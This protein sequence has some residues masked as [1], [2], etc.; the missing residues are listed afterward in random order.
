M[1]KLSIKKGNT[2]VYKRKL[3]FLNVSP[4]CH[5]TRVEQGFISIMPI[6]AI[7]V[8]TPANFDNFD[9]AGGSGGHK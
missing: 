3:I 8:I 2:K 1:Q 5:S 7:G 4:I 6:V 9:G